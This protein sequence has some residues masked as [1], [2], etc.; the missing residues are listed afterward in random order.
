M[1][2]DGVDLLEL[3]HALLTSQ[4]SGNSWIRLCMEWTFRRSACRG[5]STMSI[6]RA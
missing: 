4:N 5:R 2:K 1:V 3:S 6:E